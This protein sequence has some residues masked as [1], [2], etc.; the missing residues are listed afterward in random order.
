MNPH[1]FLNPSRDNK[2]GYYLKDG[3]NLNRFWRRTFAPNYNNLCDD[4]KEHPIPEHA[5]IVKKII[6]KYW[7]REEI[8]IYFLDFHETS[9]LKRFQDDLSV[10]LKK[11]S[12]TYKFDHWLKESIIKNV[13][14]LFDI[15]YFREPLFFKCNKT[16]DHKHINLSIKLLDIVYEKLL[17]YI[18]KNQKKLPFYFCYSE[19]SK[20]Y[21]E[22]LASN[23]YS[24]LKNKLWDTA[25]PS[26]NHKF[27]DHG[28]FVKMGDATSRPNVYSMELESQKQFFD[29]FEEIEKSKADPNYFTNK[30]KTVNLSLE[31]ALDAINELI[32]LV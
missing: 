11:E 26:F 2:S 16:I 9:L 12:I 29:L 22:K 14:T 17:D 32:K 30:L 4:Q 8:S 23:V 28:C 3:T 27:H 6:E 20:V 19:R 1:G 18:V 31:L 10:N 21:C 13:M 5:K 7:E 25:S 24:R 15:K